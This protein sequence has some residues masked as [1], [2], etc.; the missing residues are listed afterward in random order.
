MAGAEIAVFPL[1]PSVSISIGAKRTPA[2]I[3]TPVRYPDHI[4]EIAKTRIPFV[5][6]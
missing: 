1:N 2:D 4:E 5:I 6:I 3:L